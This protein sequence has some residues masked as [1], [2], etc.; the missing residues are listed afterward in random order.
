M[1]STPSGDGFITD[2]AFEH[3]FKPYFERVRDGSWITLAHRAHDDMTTQL[4]ANLDELGVF[5]VRDRLGKIAIPTLVI[6]GHLDTTHPPDQSWQIHTGI[7]GSE[8][9][10]LAH[11]GQGDVADEDLPLYRATVERFLAGLAET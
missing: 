2:P 5:D 11:T 3:E 1:F 9:L 8:F 7:P 10:L 4:R 6:A